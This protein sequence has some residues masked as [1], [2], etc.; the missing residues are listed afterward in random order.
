MTPIPQTIHARIC[1]LMHKFRRGYPVDPTHIIMGDTEYENLK[2]GCH[3]VSV[4]AEYN[5]P[6]PDIEK[7]YGLDIIRS[8]AKP[9]LMIATTEE[10]E[11]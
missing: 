10:E 1:N 9:K 8:G 11:P 3:L 4:G 7:I 6:P 5:E 2:A